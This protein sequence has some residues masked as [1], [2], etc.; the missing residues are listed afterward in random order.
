MG[1]HVRLN[2]SVQ[3]REMQAPRKAMARRKTDDFSPMEEQQIGQEWEGSDQNSW[4]KQSDFSR[5]HSDSL[6]AASQRER[7]GAKPRWVPE[8]TS[9]GCFASCALF[10]YSL[11][12]ISKDCKF[13]IALQVNDLQMILTQPK[14]ALSKYLLDLED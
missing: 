13:A 8:A 9:P 12:M 3:Y 10:Q 14:R 7:E 2:G 1:G 4:A 11:S 6:T 5:Q